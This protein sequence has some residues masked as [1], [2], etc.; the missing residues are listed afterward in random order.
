MPKKRLII[1]TTSAWVWWGVSG[2]NLH[3]IMCS[4][5]LIVTSLISAIAIAVALL[6]PCLAGLA[7]PLTSAA[8]AVAG[9]LPA[10]LAYSTKHKT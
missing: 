7:A 5:H 1:M 8:D 4:I 3:E 6:A 9:V 10:P 2:G